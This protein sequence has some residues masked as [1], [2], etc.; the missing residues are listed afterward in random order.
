MG[1]C[2]S[3]LPAADGSSKTDCVLQKQIAKQSDLSIDALDSKDTYGVARVGCGCWSWNLF[4]AMVN[5]VL[6]V[7]LDDPSL[8]K[9]C[10][11]CRLHQGAPP[12][13]MRIL[14]VQQVLTYTRK[15]LHRYS[16][17]LLEAMHLVS[18]GVVQ[19]SA[20][21][22]TCMVGSYTCQSRNTN[23]NA[24]FSPS[25]VQAFET[26]AST[27]VY[28]RKDDPIAN[29]LV[30]TLPHPVAH[31]CL[32]MKHPHGVIILSDPSRH[33]WFASA[34]H[35]ICTQI[36]LC[37]IWVPLCRQGGSDMRSSLV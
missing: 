23:H 30:Y 25:S 6:S 18:G 14:P 31:Q 15:T 21:P 3:K 36:Q 29:I 8:T 10:V 17:P 19:N 16:C 1:V 32:L 37:L 13:R 22:A 33:I 28:A 27:T 4:L 2:G 5:P 7:R 12:L 26:C 24:S 34:M 20:S 35:P 11:Q 9:L